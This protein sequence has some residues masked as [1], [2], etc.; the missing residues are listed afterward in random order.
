MGSAV[1]SHRRGTGLYP[2]RTCGYGCSLLCPGAGSYNTVP[3]LVN[4]RLDEEGRVIA[5]VKTEVEALAAGQSEIKETIATKA[6][7]MDL[8][9][10]IDRVTKNHETRMRELE[11]DRG[12]HHR[13]KN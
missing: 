1:Q 4:K 13:N 9:A 10:K 2:G 11:E 6:D 8:G 5:Q 7:V 3:P 12:I